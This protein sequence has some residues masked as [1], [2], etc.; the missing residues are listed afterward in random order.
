[1]LALAASGAAPPRGCSPITWLAVTNGDSPFAGDWRLLTT[2]SPNGDGFRDRARI[3]FRLRKAATVTVVVGWTKARVYPVYRH[4]YRFARGVHT[5]EWAPA[6]TIPPRTYLVRLLVGGASYGAAVPTRGRQTGPVVRVQGVDAAFERDSYRAGSVARLRVSTDAAELTV[7][8]FRAGPEFVPKP[9]QPALTGLPVGDPIEMPW[10]WRSQSHTVAVPIGDVPSGFCF[11]KLTAADGRVGFAPVVV[12]PRILGADA[13]VAVV[14]PTYTWQAYNF[15]DADG[16]G[17]GDTWYV[18]PPAAPITL[19]AALHRPFLDRGVPPHF[20]E[21]DEDFLHWLAWGSHDVDFLSD[22]DLE[23]FASGGQLARLYRLIV[24]AGHEEY[25]TGRAYRLVRRFRNL[26]GNLMFLSSDNFYWRV[27]RRG[28]AIRRTVSS[29]ALGR[30]EAALIG[31]QFVA[32][33]GGRRQGPYVVRRAGAAPWLF[34]ET[35]L[36]NGSRFGHFGIEVDS[37]APASP[38]QTVVLARMPV[39]NAEMTYYETAAGAKVFAFGAFT[40]GGVATQP[41]MKQL[42]DN[43]WARLERP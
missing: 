1:V 26:G 39:R 37:R 21:Y 3:H 13:H 14:L 17:W 41:P 38:R 34:H 11:A 43:L 6:A 8:L 16:N 18:G 31:A 2:I 42:L 28:G 29:R 25:V 4:R 24:F 30:P 40:L 19:R 5:V 36:N 10:R 15:E 32:N 12:R 33:D 20:A 27:V 7:Q 22:S 23:R 35:G 9:A